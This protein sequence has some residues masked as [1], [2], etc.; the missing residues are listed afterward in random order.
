MW[1]K[2]LYRNVKEIKENLYKLTWRDLQK[3]T[4]SEKR[5]GLVWYLLGKEEGEIRNKKER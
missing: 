1:Y 2:Q 5:A 3:T 4:L